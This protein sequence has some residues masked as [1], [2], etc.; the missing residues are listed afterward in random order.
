V[1]RA[2]MGQQAALAR[3][4]VIGRDHEGGVGADALGVLEQADRLDRVVGSRAGD[5]GHSVSET[6]QL[7]QPAPDHGCRP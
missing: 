4:V 7:S 6:R 1:Q 3:L 2:V 5:D